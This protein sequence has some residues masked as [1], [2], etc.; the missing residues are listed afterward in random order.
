MRGAV[1]RVAARTRSTWDDR[2]ID[3]RVFS[4]LIHTLPG[5]IVYYGVG[6]A[7]GQTPAE[8]V[9]GATTLAFAAAMT[10]RP[11]STSFIEKPL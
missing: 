4:R 6:P 3:R 2:V 11:S 8:I 9:A 7:L 10:L 1:R 5:V